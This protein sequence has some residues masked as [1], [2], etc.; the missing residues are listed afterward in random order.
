VA[1]FVA[2]QSRLEVAMRD[3]EVYVDKDGNVTTDPEAAGLTLISRQ[4]LTQIYVVMERAHERLAF[5]DDTAQ[6]GELL[7][8]LEAF[9]EPSD[10]DSDCSGYPPT[11]GGSVGQE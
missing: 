5:E 9:V 4:L 2:P 8:E 7:N 1:P 3:D 11:C 6:A 10:T